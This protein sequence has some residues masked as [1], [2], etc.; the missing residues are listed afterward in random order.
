MAEATPTPVKAKRKKKKITLTKGMVHI[1]SSFNNT[2]VSI[3][4]EKGA[5]AVWSSAGAAGF[6]GSRKSTPYAA[7]IATEKVLSQAKDLGLKKADVVV[8]GIGGGRE[9]A[10][11]ALMAAGIEIGSIRDMTGI[12]HNGCRPRKPW[13]V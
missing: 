2:I 8:K 7:Q 9:S 3:T 12:P 4:D 6:K 11:R 1:Q 5:V 10:V 13:R